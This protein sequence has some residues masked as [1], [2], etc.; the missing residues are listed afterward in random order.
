MLELY[1]FELSHY[2][3]KVRLILD[4]KGLAY[5]KIEITP[6]IGQLDIFRMSGQRQVPVLKD[7]NEVIAD[8]T[9]IAFYLDRKYPERPLIPTEPQRRSQCLILEQWADDSVGINARKLLISAV[10]QDSTFLTSALPSGTP[11]FL[12]NLVQSVPREA[13]DLVGFGAGAS[14]DAIKSA[15]K[16]MHRSLESLSEM[17]RDQPYLLGDQPTLADFAVAAMTMYVKFPIGSYL[18]LPAA[19]KGKG[20]IELINDP[21]LKPFWDWRDRLYA[22]F[23]KAPLTATVGTTSGSSSGPTSINID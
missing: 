12:R 21:L 1:Q 2:C 8:S 20:T 13:I 19:I 9:E 6:G 5:R 17:L 16:E 10:G 7:G 18:E 11:G 4:Y 3:E 14:P 23:R 15:R 22:D